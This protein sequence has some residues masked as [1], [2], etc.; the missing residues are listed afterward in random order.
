MLF[1]D[2]ELGA[3]KLAA[4][5]EATVVDTRAATEAD[6]V[7]DTVAD[8]VADKEIRRIKK[9]KKRGASLSVS[10]S[11]AKATK[12]Q[13]T[14]PEGV[15]P[16]HWQDW[17]THRKAK[18]ASNTPSAWSR[19]ER[20][21]AKARMTIPSVVQT[22]AERSWVGFECSWVASSVPLSSSEYKPFVPSTSEDPIKPKRRSV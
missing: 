20:E 5:E 3:A 8:K 15:D 14:M 11:K 18:R 17:L 10:P 2:G 22:C 19:I 16:T 12:P 1:Q 13:W 6:T 7:E 9:V 21:A 4:T